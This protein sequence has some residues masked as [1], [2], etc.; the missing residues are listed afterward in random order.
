MSIS[1][2]HPLVT[3]DWLADH[4]S[5]PNIRVI[6]IRGHVLPASQPA[7]HYFNH[8]DDYGKSHIPSALFVDWVRA[9]T[10]PADPRHATIAK[11]DRYQALMRTLGVNAD[12]LVIA[13]DDAAGMFAARLWWTLNYYGH[14][15]VAIVDG[16]WPKWIAESRPVTDLV[17]DVAPGNFVAQANEQWRRTGDQVLAA[18]DSPTRLVDVRSP[19]EFAGKYA[20]AQRTGHIPGAV[21]VP[22]TM[23]INTDGT[24]LSP[25]KLRETFAAQGIDESSPEVVMYCNGGVSASYGLLAL[26]LAGLPHG[27]VYDGSWKEWGNDPS[28]PIVAD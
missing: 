8:H 6:D 18:I 7:P 10:D 25:T 1:P 2:A 20:R 19:E 27:T 15:Q 22:R 13:Y 21:N 24:M 11:A 14:A 26:Q 17:S 28:K 12:T 4:L 9:I 5:D 3:T 23:L 16:G